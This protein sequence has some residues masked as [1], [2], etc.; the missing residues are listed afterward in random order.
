MYLKFT[1]KLIQVLSEEIL[2][3]SAQSSAAIGISFS[4]KIIKIYKAMNI[5]ES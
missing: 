1:K 3:Q 2:N 4:K 5:M